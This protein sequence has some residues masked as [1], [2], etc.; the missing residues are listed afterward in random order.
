MFKKEIREFC[1][2]LESLRDFINLVDAHLT[3]KTKDEISSDPSGFVPLLIMLSKQFPEQFG[4]ENEKIEKAKKLFG[5]EIDIM[6]E[7]DDD[8]TKYSFDMSDD[9]QH[10]FSFAMNKLSKNQ[11]RKSSLYQSS[12]VTV[13]SYVEWF[14]AQI[15]HK[16]YD[17]NPN[18]VGLKDKQISLEDLYNFGSID[19]AKKYLI[20]IKVESVLRGSFKDWI[21]FLKEQMNLSMSYLKDHENDL[22]EACQRRNLYVHNGGIVNSIYSKNCEFLE[23]TPELGSKLP[24]D[25]DYL[26]KCLSAFEKSFLL[27]ACELWKKN[28]PENRERY[29]L[30]NHLSYEHISEGRYEVGASIAYFL[31]GDKKQKESDRTVCQ[32]NY[33]QAMKWSGEFDSVKSEI[34]DADFSAKDSIYVLAKH[35]LLDEFDSALKM[36]PDLVKSEKLTIEDL[37][38][39]PLFRAIREQPEYEIMINELQPEEAQHPTSDDTLEEDTSSGANVH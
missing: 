21:K 36:M 34:K 22:I 31:C 25:K 27:I 39:W 26:D 24:C 10:K 11:D 5:H 29:V 3:E 20:D 33:W 35:A 2:N 17:K 15:I 9:A 37:R 23:N 32:I 7:D 28:E 38:E 13:I 1:R 12:L 18:A 8:G 30:M 16:F 14:L 6:E 4:L 19:D